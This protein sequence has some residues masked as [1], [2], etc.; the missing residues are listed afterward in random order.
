MPTEINRKTY[1][2]P[3]SAR[4]EYNPFLPKLWI[5][6]NSFSI[7]LFSAAGSTHCCMY[8]CTLRYLSSETEYM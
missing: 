5:S 4:V 3:V 2:T 6:G 1:L 8:V 7:G